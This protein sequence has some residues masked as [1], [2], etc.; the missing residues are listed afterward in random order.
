MRAR[1]RTLACIDRIWQFRPSQAHALELEWQVHQAPPGIL[2]RAKQHSGASARVISGQ[3]LQMSPCRTNGRGMHM[4]K[5]MQPTQLKR[6]TWP[7]QPTRLMRPTPPMQPTQHMLL[8]WRMDIRIKRCPGTGLRFLFGESS[9]LS[10][11]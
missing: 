5:D 2:R 11:C 3:S 6:L 9:V 4:H 8:K 7:T 1:H 10:S